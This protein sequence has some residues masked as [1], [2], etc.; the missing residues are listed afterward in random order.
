VSAPRATR[1]PPLLRSI[2]RIWRIRS[3]DETLTPAAVEVRGAR[4]RCSR[5]NATTPVT[6]RVVESTG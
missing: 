6:S 3:V 5:T 1:T 4:R 2:A